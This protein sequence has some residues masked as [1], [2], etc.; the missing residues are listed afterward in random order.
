VKGIAELSLLVAV[1]A[2]CW[3]RTPVGAV[4][5]AGLLLVRGDRVEDVALPD[6]LASFRTELPTTLQHALTTTVAQ[7]PAVTAVELGVGGPRTWTPA[8]RTAVVAQL[9]DDALAA[10]DAEA[11]MSGAPAFDA[12]AALERWSVGADTRQRAIRRARAAGVREPDRYRA[13]R[14]FLPD[15][16]ALAADRAVDETLALATVL[17]LSWPVDPA[18]RITSGFGYRTHPTLRTRKLHEGVDIAVPVGT[19]VAAAGAGTVIRARSN[20]VCGRHVKLDHGHGVT[21]SYCHGDLV[22]VER[23][24]EVR[25]GQEIMK[26]GNT[27][28]STGPHLHFGLRIGGRPVDPAAFRARGATTRGFAGPD[29]TASG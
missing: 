5:S 21:T 1:C 27:G 22:E 2:A 11:S 16:D 7:I 23:G 25:R 26:S 19:A 3:T 9:G 17:D 20:A 6:L 18:A 29:E 14:R 28:R 4:A 24:V 13:H 10:L 12:E 15:A 8:L